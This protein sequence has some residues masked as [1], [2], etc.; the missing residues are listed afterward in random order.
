VSD[1]LARLRLDYRSALV[2]YLS[3]R[4]ETQLASAYELGRGAILG[5]VGLLELVQ[6]HNSVTLDLIRAAAGS[7]ERLEVAEAAAAFLVEVLASSE[8]A[9]RGFLE[10][11]R[12]P[13]QD[14]A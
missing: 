9:R 8:M 12:G 2:G 5:Q 13:G 14:P 1:A 4:G 11:T 3:R 7:D 6:L 10:S